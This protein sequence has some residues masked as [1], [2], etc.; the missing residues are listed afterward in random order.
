[1]ARLPRLSV[2]GVPHL[3]VQ[4]GHNQQVVF[5]DDA[6]RV[7]FRTLLGEAA[8]AEGVTLHAY[9]LMAAEFRLLATPATAESLGRMM[10]VLGRRYGAAFNRRHS[11][12]GGLWEG[13]FRATVLEAERHLLDAMGYIEHEGN[14]E[15]GAV[16]ADGPA[17]SSRGHHLGQRRDPLLS[18][19]A[20][21]WA[22]GNT[23]FDRDIAYR[24]RL[25]QGLSSR[26]RAQI[27]HA[28]QKGWPL[29]SEAFVA[30]LSSHTERRLAPLRRGRPAKAGAE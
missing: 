25:E 8:R 7:L 23:P 11:R 12:T 22:L 27:E 21:F 28:V 16:E 2:G 19:H 26:E 4:R 14:W 1:M 15:G 10:Q 3:L 17:A 30:T 24:K 13:R 6:D 5:A 9:G 18:D 29:G 20:V